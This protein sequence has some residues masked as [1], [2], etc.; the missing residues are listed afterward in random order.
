MRKRFG[1]FQRKTYNRIDRITGKINSKKNDTALDKYLNNV[2]YAKLA[3]IRKDNK[4][5]TDS[6]V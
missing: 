2:L 6:I 4:S 3:E 1:I 5:L